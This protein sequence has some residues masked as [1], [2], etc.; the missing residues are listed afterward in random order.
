MIK[1]IMMITSRF[2]AN[3][4]IN[5]NKKISIG[6]E[7]LIFLCKETDYLCVNPY[8][9]DIIKTNKLWGSHGYQDREHIA[10]PGQFL[11]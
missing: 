1:K 3:D 2:I 8:Y 7:N 5:P 6:F 11:S 4:K 9:G 10:E